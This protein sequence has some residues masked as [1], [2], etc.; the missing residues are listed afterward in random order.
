MS[1]FG[2]ENNNQKI[3]EY[4]IEERKKEKKEEKKETKEPK[5]TKKSE[6]VN[7]DN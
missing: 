2:I 3:K 1:Y 7:D 6:L 4:T 5:F